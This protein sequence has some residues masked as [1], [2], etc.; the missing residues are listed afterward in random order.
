VP[1]DTLR[2]L[3]R[4]AEALIFPSVYEGFGLPVLEAMAAGTPILAMP[5]SSVPEVGGDCVL[6]PDGLSVAALARAIERL[7]TDEVL[8]EELRDRGSRWVEQFTWEKTARATYQV[9]RSAVL[10]PSARS[11]HMRRLLRDAILQWSGTLSSHQPVAPMGILNACNALN[12]AVQRRL[13]NDLKRLP[14]VVGR[15]RA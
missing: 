2:A 15:K 9:Y 7:A 14:T 5:I 3:Y 12:L 8:R 4:S 11:L 13:R 1:A 10:R 6:Y